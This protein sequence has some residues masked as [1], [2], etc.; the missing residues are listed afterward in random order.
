MC[1]SKAYIER[2]GKR[3]LVM[4]EVASLRLEDEKLR[5]RTLLGEQKEI[6]ANIKEI[7]FLTHSITLEDPKTR[8]QAQV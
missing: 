1:L 4:G 3:E 5:L 8:K 2:S 6:D 7:D